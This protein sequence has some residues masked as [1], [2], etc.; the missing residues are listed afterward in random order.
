MYVTMSITYIYF[1]F[2][3]QAENKKIIF[4]RAE[5]YIKEYRGKERDEIRLKRQAKKNDNFYVPAESRLAF[6]CRIRG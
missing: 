5:K 4:K 6:V 3:K 2:Q 1:I